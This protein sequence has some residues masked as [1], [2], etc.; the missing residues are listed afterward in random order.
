MLVTDPVVGP[1]QPGLEISEHTGHPRQQP[2]RPAGVVSP[3]SG[4]MAVA[5]ARQRRVALPTVRPDHRP[6][7]DVDF[8]EAGQGSRRGVGDD[9]EPNPPGALPPYL[10]GRHDQR[11]VLKG[12][13]TP[14]AGFRAAEIRLV[15]LD[16]D[17]ER[18]A[19]GPNHRPPELVE[20][21]PRGL[22]A[23]EPQ[24]ALELEGRQTRGVR[25][26][27]VGSPEPLRQGRSREDYGPPLCVHYSDG[28]VR[29]VF[30]VG[31]RYVVLDDSDPRGMEGERINL[32]AFK[33]LADRCRHAGIPLYVLL[34]PTKET[35]FRAR[36]EASLRNE[37][38]LVDLWQA[39][40][41]ARRRAMAFFTREGIRTID[42]LPALEAMIASGVN[43]YLENTDGHP[44]ARGYD[45]I[46]RA[47]A[48]RL[49]RDG[50]GESR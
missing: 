46:A 8:D 17:V 49:Q 35:A 15:H 2:G 20:H 38:Y 40:A 10:D 29:T 16:L 27:D 14:E 33:H 34:L 23:S 1:P 50:A 12:P 41:R 26:H 5:H 44:A 24:V 19:V 39:E 25:R 28:M 18:L 42:T 7:F 21:P 11:L 6:L 30:N 48:A 45:A 31:Y 22:V 3:G 9:L 47:I 43:P 13:S 36:A 32:L 4:S 37:P